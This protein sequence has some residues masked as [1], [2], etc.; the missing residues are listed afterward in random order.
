[1]P[2]NISIFNESTSIPFTRFLPT[3]IH[4]GIQVGTEFEGKIKNHWRFYPSINIGYMIHKK[5]FQGI[6]L[7][8]D[9]GIDYQTNIGINL[10]C[11]MGIGY[12]HTFTTQQEFQFN[13]NEYQNKFDWGNARIM[14]SMSLGLGYDL[15]KENSRSAEIYL[16]Y[17]SWIEY[18]YS[19]GFIPLMTHTNLHLGTKFYPFK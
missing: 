7:S 1:M 13:G 18:P 17:Q 12:L 2:V 11:K 16:L 4:P 10:K 3:P 14:P 8:A 19:P 5:L 15:D 6:N 9:V